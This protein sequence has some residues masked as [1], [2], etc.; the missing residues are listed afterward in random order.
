MSMTIM[1]TGMRMDE[2]PAA[3]PAL[4]A[5]CPMIIGMMIAPIEAVPMH[6]PVADVELLYERS[7]VESVVGYIPLIE[8]PAPSTAMTFRTVPTG[9]IRRKKKAKGY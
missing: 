4:S 1:A 3:T 8:R 5:A 9:E 6:I 7:I 2:K